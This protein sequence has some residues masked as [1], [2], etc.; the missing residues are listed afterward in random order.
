VT[1]QAKGARR[2][3]SDHSEGAGVIACFC[4]YHPGLNGQLKPLL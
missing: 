2:E 3:I 1:A 4:K